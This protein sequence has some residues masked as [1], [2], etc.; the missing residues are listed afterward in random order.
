MGEIVL[1]NGGVALVDDN[2]V[3]WLSEHRWRADGAGYAQCRMY[4]GGKRR[5][6]LMH[7]LIT[8]AKAGQ[9]VDHMNHRKLDNQRAN[10]RPCT[11]AEN[12]RNK[13]V[14]ASARS[15]LKGAR[16]ATRGSGWEAMIHLRG[17]QVHLGSYR[18]PYEAAQAYDHAA[19]EHFG[20]FAKLNFSPDRDWFIPTISRRRANNHD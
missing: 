8:G 3:A 1:I 9:P 6:V 5:A 17:R 4:I 19:T 15:G 11:P 10:L 13:R 7:R 2:D 16:R 18:T 20:E 12:S 14:L